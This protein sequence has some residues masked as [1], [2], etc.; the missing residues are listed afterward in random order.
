MASITKNN[1][2]A[3]TETTM[4]K[5]GAVAGAAISTTAVV[6]T[7]VLAAGTILT[8]GALLVAAGVGAALGGVFGAEID[9][10]TSTIVAGD[11]SPSDHSFLM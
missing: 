3:P 11:I 1:E 4:A 10:Y 5:E 2:A 8:G 7:A 9:H 6:T